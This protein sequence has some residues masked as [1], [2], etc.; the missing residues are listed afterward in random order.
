MRTSFIKLG[1][2]ALVPFFMACEEESTSDC[3][4]NFSSEVYVPTNDRQIAIPVFNA[5]N[6]VNGRFSVEPKGLDIDPTT[7]AIDVNASGSGVE[8]Y[9]TFKDN[10]ACICERTVIISGIDYLDKIIDLNSDETTNAPIFEADVNQAPPAGYFYDSKDLVDGKP[11]SRFIAEGLAIDERTG[12]IDAKKTLLNLKEEGE[13]IKNGYYKEFDVS[14][15]FEEEPDVW[16]ETE[17]ELYYF[18]TQADIPQSVLDEM[19]ERSEFP[20]SGR[21]MH[22]HGIICGVGSL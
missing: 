20:K 9:L 15:S 6:P 11:N 16:Y 19:E 17:V 18:R 21:L 13:E 1:V 7:G 12:A 4:F 22:R 2:I 14:Y 3:T 10:N 8:Y 5:T